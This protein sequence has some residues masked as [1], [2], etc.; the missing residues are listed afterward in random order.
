MNLLVVLTILIIVMSAIFDKNKTQ[1]GLKRWGKMFI[2]IL[3]ALLSVIILISMAMYAT[4]KDFLLKIFGL[5]SSSYSIIFAALIGSIIII[6]GFIAYPVCGY[7]IKGGVSYHVEAVF[8][9][10]AIIIEKYLKGKKYKFK[11]VS[12]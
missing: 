7:L 9:I 12:S 10:I 8:I 1:E 11:D 2:K 3:P 4:T 5:G 6:S